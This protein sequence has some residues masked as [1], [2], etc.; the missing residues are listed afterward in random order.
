MPLL[1]LA[2]APMALLAAIRPNFRTAPVTAAIVLFASNG[3]APLSSA[4]D[5]IF[6][7]G[8]GTLI[9]IVVSIMVLPSRAKRI[10]F[11][12]S[13]EVLGLLGEVLALHL[14]PPAP[15]T[16]E[17]IE[18]L[19]AQVRAGLGKVETAAQEARREHA[20]RVAGESVPGS[21]VRALRRLRSD[22]AF[23]GRATSA[24]DL[25]WQGLQPLLDEVASGFRSIL[26]AVADTLAHGADLP[27][28]AELDGTIA[29]LNAAVGEASNDGPASRGAAVLPFVVDTLRRDLGELVNVLAAGADANP[30]AAE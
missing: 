25:D 7:V 20:M 28:F 19:N 23:V 26:A 10:G 3:A 1:L 2:V 29:K 6:E 9:G 17:A 12:R 30:V 14:Q 5:R 15:A 11:G 16:R 18:R 22:I 27:D 8:L 13:A 24:D 4:V 21:L